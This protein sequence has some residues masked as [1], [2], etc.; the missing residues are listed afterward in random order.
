MVDLSYDLPSL[1]LNCVCNA[2]DDV[3]PSSIHSTWFAA[4]E[5][6]IITLL[7]RYVVLLHF[8]FPVP[9]FLVY[10]HRAYYSLVETLSQLVLRVMMLLYVL[11]PT[12][13]DPG[14]S[15]GVLYIFA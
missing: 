5:A 7:I 14:S 3:N 15:I 6:R 10:V 12:T 9:S 11:K 13:L 4:L 2:F 1:Y 8:V